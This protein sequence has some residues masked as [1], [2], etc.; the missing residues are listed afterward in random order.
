MSQLLARHEIIIFLAVLLLVIVVGAVNPAFFSFFNMFS[1]L[2]NATVPGLFALG[3]FIVLVIG[4]LD[5]SFTAVGVVAMYST[6]VLSKAFFPDV[7]IWLLFGVAALIGGLLGLINGL[8]VNWLKVSSLIITLG[9]MSLFRGFLLYFV[10]TDTIRQLPPAMVAFS[11]T[12]VLT[13]TAENG[14]RVGLHASVAIFL[15]IAALV[16]FIMRYTTVG[17]SLYAIGGNRVAAARM[18]INVPRLECLAYALSG[19]LA[20]IAG[21]MSAAVIR[22]ANPLTLVGSELDVIAAVVIG[23]AAITGGGGSVIGVLLGT[24]LIVV[25]DNSLIIL[26]VS[27]SWQKV[28]IGALLIIAI[29]LPLLVRR[30]RGSSPAYGLVGEP[31]AGE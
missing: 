10:G 8:L 12:N 29:G 18:G 19:L 13:M 2:K 31:E 5:V 4:G 15:V 28:A 21:L 1:M 6:V 23:G 22:L 26:G 20:G 7:S 16:L 14:A 9:T 24:L 3:F 17:R 27:A 11:R 30:Q 25:T